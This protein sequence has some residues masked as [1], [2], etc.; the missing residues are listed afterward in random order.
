M[1]QTIKSLLVLATKI[2][3]L[4]VNVIIQKIFSYFVRV[5]ISNKLKLFDKLI[6]KVFKKYLIQKF[7][8]EGLRRSTWVIRNFLKNQANCSPYGLPWHL[9]VKS[10]SKIAT[11][12][13]CIWLNMFL[14]LRRFASIQH[15]SNVPIFFLEI[16]YYQT[17]LLLFFTLNKPILV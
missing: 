4:K 6:Y 17:G 9:R 10:D 14:K 16:S 8:L 11:D 1:I 15:T 12:C 3:I 5:G 13:Y 7:R 2:V